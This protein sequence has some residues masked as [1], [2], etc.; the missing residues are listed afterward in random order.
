MYIKMVCLQK[1]DRTAKGRF[2]LENQFEVEG[3]R[4]LG[5]LG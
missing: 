5:D 2:L 3:E 4:R 1:I